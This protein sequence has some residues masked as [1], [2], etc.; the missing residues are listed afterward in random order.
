MTLRTGDRVRVQCV[1]STGAPSYEY[2]FL[3]SIEPD[4][5]S[6]IV[7]VDH[8]LQPWRVSLEHVAAV[9]ITTVELCLDSNDMF[10]SIGHDATLR[11]DLVHRWL[12][13]A[14]EAGLDLEGVEP[15]DDGVHAGLGT[16]PLAEVRSA[17]SRFLLRVEINTVKSG[18]LRIH[19][20]SHY[21]EN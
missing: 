11:R 7:I 19:A 18:V 4:R 13:E 2:G 10:R 5:T 21:P 3:E 12:A 17:G 16:W 20:V 15:L 8:A 6:A 14:E 1:D 9:A